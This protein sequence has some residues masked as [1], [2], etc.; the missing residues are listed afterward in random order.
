MGEVEASTALKLISNLIG[1]TNVAV[2]AEG[3][4]LGEK[5]GIDPKMLLE[6]LEDTGANSFQ[7]GLRGNWIADGDFGNRFG[8]DL[9]LKDVRLGCEMADNWGL[10]ARLM[11]Q[12][13]DYLKDASTQGYGTEDCNAIYKVVK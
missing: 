8:L 11:K 3:M 1:M 7:L 4:R 5:A 9:A 6:L 10:D 12:A 2:V 13:L